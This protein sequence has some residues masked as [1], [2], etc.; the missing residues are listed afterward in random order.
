MEVKG[1]GKTVATLCAGIIENCSKAIEKK[2]GMISSIAF[3]AVILSSLEEV[4]PDAYKLAMKTLKMKKATELENSLF[5][6]L[7]DFE[8]KKLDETEEDDAHDMAD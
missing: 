5:A 8:K 1:T 4:N 7:S 3:A 6:K 2:D